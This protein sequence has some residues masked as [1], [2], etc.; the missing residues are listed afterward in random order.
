MQKNALNCLYVTSF[1]SIRVNIFLWV[2][3]WPSH[4]AFLWFWQYRR[5]NCVDRCRLCV[6]KRTFGK[7]KRAIGCQTVRWFGLLRFNCLIA[8]VTAVLEF[9]FQ[10]RKQHWRDIK[11]EIASIAIVQCKA[12]LRT[13]ITLLPAIVRLH[14]HNTGPMQTKFKTFIFFLETMCRQ[15]AVHLARSKIIK[16]TVT[17]TQKI[18]HFINVKCT[19]FQADTPV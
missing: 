16:N 19:H 12:K 8:A 15:V 2:Q 3:S 11:D 6:H 4:G 7:H 18:G 1:Y 13:I 10:R 17:Q 9:K 14:P 5:S